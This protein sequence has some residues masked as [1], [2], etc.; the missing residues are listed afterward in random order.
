MSG[1][2]YF[3]EHGVYVLIV[4]LATFVLEQLDK[5]VHQRSSRLDSVVATL[6]SDGFKLSE[7]H[8]RGRELPPSE[9]NLV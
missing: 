2:L 7:C 6:T 1:F 3:A 9:K 5:M 8:E 4:G